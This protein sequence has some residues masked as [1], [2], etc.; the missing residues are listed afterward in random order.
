MC[1]V[2]GVEMVTFG[3]TDPLENS[4]QI[5]IVSPLLNAQRFPIVL[6]QVTVSFDITNGLGERRDNATR[7]SRLSSRGAAPRQPDNTF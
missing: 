6:P 7:E 2:F 1:E 4:P 3:T 5:L